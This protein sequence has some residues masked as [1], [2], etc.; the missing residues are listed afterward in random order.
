LELMSEAREV[1]ATEGYDPAFG[2][3]P[4]KRAIQRLLQNPLALAVLEGRFT[5]GDHIVV[6]R[7]PKGELTFRKAK[8]P[9]LAGR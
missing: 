6:E 1:L 4:L 3:R 9:A 2:A 5:E 7:D 8:E